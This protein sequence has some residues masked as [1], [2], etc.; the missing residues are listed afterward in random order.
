AHAHA[1]DGARDLAGRDVRHA[2]D[3]HLGDRRMRGDE[4]LQLARADVLALAD[5]DVLATA[6][7]AEV[8]G[9]VQRAEIAATAPSI[10]G[11]GFAAVEVAEE[12]LGSAREDLPLASRVDV[13]AVLVDD[14]H[15]VRADRA[16]VA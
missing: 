1:D 3:R 8:A 16:S 2:D 14:P 7:D 10:R 12:A 4:I 9:V 15:F 6:G 13:G 11:E 5:D